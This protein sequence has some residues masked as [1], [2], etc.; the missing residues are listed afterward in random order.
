MSQQQAPAAPSGAQSPMEVATQ[1]WSNF[2]NGVHSGFMKMTPEK[3]IRLVVIVGAYALIR[4]YLMKLGAKL[5]AR[6]H[7]KEVDLAGLD[8]KSQDAIRALRGGKKIEIPGVDSDSEGEEEP[9]PAD[10]GKKARLRQRK[11]IRGKVEEEE[12]RRREEDEE[13]DEELEE[14]L[15]AIQVAPHLKQ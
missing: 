12:R 14:I 10:W 2:E 15:N 3:W 13:T 4:P 6:E 1:L 5:Q 8:P 9:K 7:E 11:F